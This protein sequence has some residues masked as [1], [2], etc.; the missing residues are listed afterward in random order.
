M[1]KETYQI[2]NPTGGPPLN[3]PAWASEETMRNIATDIGVMSQID[4][5]LAK[6]I[7]EFSKDLGEAFSKVTDSATA[8]TAGNNET[9]AVTKNTTKQTKKLARK[10]VDS[11]SFMG[12]TE[13]PLTSIVGALKEA[14]PAIGGAL[15]QFFGPLG[16]AFGTMENG[17]ISKLGSMIKK[18][19]DVISDAAFMWLGWN[20]GKLEAFAEVQK[21]MIDNGAIIFENGKAFNELRLSVNA[22]GV[23]YDAFSKTIAANGSAINAFG[24]NVSLGTRRFADF[25][26]DLERSAD[27]LGDFG[28]SNAELLQ[29]TGEFLEYQRMVGG[30][31]RGTMGLEDD[32]STAFTQ[33]QLET[34]GLASITGMQRSQLLANRLQITNV[35]FA[36]GLK[37]LQGDEKEAADEA[38]KLFADLE[39]IA[40]TTTPIS[41]LSNAL[42]RSL[43]VANGNLSQLSIEEVAQAM[44]ATDVAALKNAFGESIFDELEVAIQSGDTEAVQEVMFSIVNADLTRLG[45]AQG[46]ISDALA[47]ASNTLAQAMLQV[48]QTFGEISVEEYRQARLDAAAGLAEAGTSTKLLNDATK[49]FLQIQNVF[50]ANMDTLATAFG[51]AADVVNDIIQYFNDNADKMFLRDDITDAHIE[52]MKEVLKVRAMGLSSTELAY[53]TEL[54]PNGKKY[55]DALKLLQEL[56]NFDTSK[57]TNE[58]VESYEDRTPP[59]PRYFGGPVAANNPYIVGDG[60]NMSQAELFVPEVDGKILSNRELN[61]IVTEPLTDDVDSSIMEVNIQEEYKQAIAT[62]KQ[63][64]AVLDK[65]RRYAKNKMM[66]DRLK[67]AIDASG[68]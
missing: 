43:A 67:A 36:A 59:E 6:T 1:A 9:A 3:I 22:S 58:L 39:S 64:L 7:S 47:G 49:A 55:E 61:D 11:T 8:D 33:L 44:N 53:Y 14:G 31:T 37:N 63:T 54:D 17:G 34:A 10:I 5:T 28:I 57:I 41:T 26:G 15:G 12:N 66:D 51:G 19:G 24:G 65:M 62:K 13:R 32:L 30:L 18:N 21:Q 25:F 46:S 60:V 40:G 29:Q 23:T 48:Q 56:E 45:T 35:D 52:A 2:D 16:K 50:T 4:K 20:V 68:A 38:R 27:A 42:A